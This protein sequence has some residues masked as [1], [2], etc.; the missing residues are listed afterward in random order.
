LP[1]TGMRR[2]CSS[3]R[4][5]VRKLKPRAFTRKRS[6]EFRNSFHSSAP[7]NRQSLGCNRTLRFA[8]WRRGIIRP[9][10]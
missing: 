4:S 5:G 2:Y 9:S 8:S 3:S 6:G 1:L 7:R 10:R